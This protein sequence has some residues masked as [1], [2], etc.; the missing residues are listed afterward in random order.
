M[1]RRVQ[2]RHGVGSIPVIMFSGKVGRHRRARGRARRPGVPRQAV[3]PAAVDRRDEAASYGRRPRR[4]H[5]GRRAPRRAG[6]TRS[7]SPSRSSATRASSGSRSPPP[8]RSWPGARSVL[9]ARAYGRVRLDGGPLSLGAQGGHRAARAPSRRS[10]SPDPLISATVGQSIPSGHAATSFAGAVILAV[11]PA[12]RSSGLLPARRRDRVLAG[13]RRRP[14]PLRRRR[15]RRSSAPPSAARFSRGSDFFGRPQQAGDDQQERRHQADPDP[16]AAPGRRRSRRGS[17]S[18]GRAR[19]RSRSLR[20]R[21]MTIPRGTLGGSSTPVARR[22]RSTRTARPTKKTSLPRRPVCQPVTETVKPSIETVYQLMNELSAR[23]RPP[24]H[25]RPSP[26]ARSAPGG[27][28]RWARSTLEPERGLDL[29]P[30]RQREEE[31]QEEEDAEEEHEEADPRARCSSRSARRAHGG[32]RPCIANAR[33]DRCRVDGRVRPRWTPGG[34]GADEQPIL[35][36]RGGRPQAGGRR[37]LP[38]Q[39]P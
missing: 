12:A 11:P 30:D 13:L 33:G 36:A 7:S 15:G 31:R 39:V 29:L 10:R 4:P 35:A 19:R 32:L 37:P 5:L 34:R 26:G 3:R 23:T 9:R 25:A 8:S 27:S 14:L 20:A 22:T 18:G 2:E 6:S 28:R 1:L 16:D 24:T 21:A 17:R 38:R